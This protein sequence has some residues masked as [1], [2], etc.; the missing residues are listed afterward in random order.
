MELAEA[1]EEV[2]DMAAGP[3]GAGGLTPFFGPLPG[4][5]TADAEASAAGGAG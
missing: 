4:P 3:S 5:A 1:A 2:V